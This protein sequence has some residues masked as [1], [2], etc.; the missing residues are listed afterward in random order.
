MTSQVTSSSVKDGVLLAKMMI[1]KFCVLSLFSGF[2]LLAVPSCVCVEVVRKVLEN[3]VI[4]DV[5]YVVRMEQ[6]AFLDCCVA[7][8]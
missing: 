5:T 2:R 3:R 7:L 6:R 4:C 8:P 1:S